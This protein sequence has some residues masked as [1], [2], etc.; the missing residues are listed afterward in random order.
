MGL[1]DGMCDVW[2]CVMVCGGDMWCC[3]SSR[4][5]GMFSWEVL[6]FC[7]SSHTP[8]VQDNSL[9]ALFAC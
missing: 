4:I 8:P 6:N 1:C 5:V 7:Y 2:E 9:V 3:V